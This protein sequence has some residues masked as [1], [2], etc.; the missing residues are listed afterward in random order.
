ML[1]RSNA[2]SGHF[3][4]QANLITC[5]MLDKVIRAEFLGFIPDV[6]Y[7]ELVYVTLPLSLS[8]LEP[9]AFALQTRQ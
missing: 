9:R 7:L 8:S 3:R 4:S 5:I 1:S 2:Q 6:L